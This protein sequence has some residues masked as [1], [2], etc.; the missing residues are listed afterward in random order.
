MSFNSLKF[1]EKVSKCLTSYKNVT[2]NP[3]IFDLLKKY[4]AS[5]WK[6]MTFYRNSKCE[7]YSEAYLINKINMHKFKYFYNTI[8]YSEIQRIY[9]N[10]KQDI[11]LI[12]KFIR[13]DPYYKGDYHFHDNNSC[14]YKVL[15][16]ALHETVRVENTELTK[17]IKKNDIGFIHDRMGP[18]KI[19]NLINDYSYSLHIY[20][21]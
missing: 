10:E 4:D 14:Y 18:H 17:V 15:E 2:N 12:I 20:Y 13:W 5:E 7:E 3:K 9:G 6:N 11:D 16:G 1:I 8:Q 19:K 21:K